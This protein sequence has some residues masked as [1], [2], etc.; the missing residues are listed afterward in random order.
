MASPTV[1]IFSASSSGISRSNSSSKAITSST[2]SSESAPRSSMNFALGLTSSSSTPSCS[3]MISLTR[4][5]T[6]FAMNTSRFRVDWTH[7][8]DAA[9][10]PDAVSLPRQPPLHVQAAIDMDGLPGDVSGAVAGQES[11]HLRHLPR[12]ADTL[13]RHLLEQGLPRLRRDRRGHVRLDQTRRPGIDQDVAVRQLARG[14]LREADDA[15]L[16]R[17][18]VDLAGIAHGP[19]RGRY[20]NDAPAFLPHHRLG[21]GPG[22][23]KYAP[24]V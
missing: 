22:H 19:C 10:P 14:R 6:G 17:R 12:R 21:D 5:S 4:S 13:E 11:Y 8:A 23:Q 7:T 1:V 20:V 24:E 9:S 2:V 3:T 16:R 18:V 15:R